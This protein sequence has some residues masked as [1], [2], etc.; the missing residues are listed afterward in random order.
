ML[1]IADMD[2]TLTESR[3][4]AEKDI[5]AVICKILQKHLFCIISGA[6]YERIKKQ[7]LDK[8]PIVPD[9]KNMY[10][11]AQSGAEIYDHSELIH[12]K[13]MSETD[14]LL[15]KMLLRG[16]TLS[17]EERLKKSG[18]RIGP[19]NPLIVDKGSQVTFSIAGVNTDIEIK[20]R[21]DP[22]A[23][24]RKVLVERLRPFLP[25]HIRMAIGGTTSIDFTPEEI[26]KRSGVQYLQKYLSIKTND[27]V[28]IGDKCFKGGND[29]IGKEYK[30]HNV[31]SP[32]ETLKILKGLACP[33]TTK[34]K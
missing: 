1:V 18:V 7:V 2:G 28:Y 16:L 20:K 3:Q 19:L 27:V 26:S 30:Y 15:V 32:E 33:K 34:K 8:M 29:W 12:K 21:I 23:S 11:V 25:P 22:D 5:I 10:V 17:H 31:S 14:K 13:S 6:T 9:I 24:L 4:E